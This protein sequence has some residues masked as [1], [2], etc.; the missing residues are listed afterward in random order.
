MLTHASVVLP[1]RPDARPG[2]PPGRLEIVRAIPPGS[3]R[4]RSQRAYLAALAAD[5][6]LAGLRAD[7]R[8]TVMELARIWARHADWQ[9]M[10]AWRPRAK[11]CAEVGSSRN[12][13]VPLSVTAYKAA[14]C[15]LQ[16][17][18]WLGLVSQ[19]WTSALRALALDDGTSVSAVFVL[20]I[21]RRK[22]RLPQPGEA[23]PVNRPL[24]RSGGPVVKAPAR[25]R[26][27]REPQPHQGPRSART[28]HVP[29]PADAL[30]LSKPQIRSEGLAA[31]A[32]VIQRAGVLRALSREHVAS[33]IR[34]F[35]A[36][37]WAAGDL[38]GAV[39]HE[40]AGRP[41]GYAREVRHPAGWLRHRLSLWLGGAGPL[42]SPSQRRAAGRAEVLAGQQARR[43]ERQRGAE[44]AA[45]VDVAQ[46]VAELRAIAAARR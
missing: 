37:G 36:A 4:A 43:D 42:P 24:T 41:H 18:G 39:D 31:A 28:A 1:A 9:T 21:P 29:P 17:H 15:W 13:D 7:A 26:P 22:P 10:T 2:H 40:P 5:P 35:V 16:D 25:A 3:R 12:P 23:G 32:V 44:R 33:I 6:Q 30:G 19:G 34:P 27:D 38:L 20:A 11:M 45:Q 14:R 8:R 46:R